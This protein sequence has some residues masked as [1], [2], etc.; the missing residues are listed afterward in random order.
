MVID[1]IPFHL[2]ADELLEQLHLDPADDY[3]D[4]IA[5]LVQK[6]V[7]IARPKVLLKEAYIE[8]RDVDSVTISGAVFVSRV[9]HANTAGIDRVIAF[10]ATCGHELD[11]LQSEYDDPLLLYCLDC[12]KAQ[13]LKTARKRL[14]DV[15]AHQFGM[16]K[17][18]SMSPGSGDASVWPIE[19][20]KQ[21]F[22]LMGDVG[23]LIGVQLTASCLMQ[24][25]KTVSGIIFPTEK[26]FATCQLC[27]REHCPGRQ[28][29]FNEQLWQERQMPGLSM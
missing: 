19:Q 27:H 17:T 23:S 9:L 26:D 5:L 15:V 4:D 12:I 28:A 16:Q 29:P 2:S 18:A 6:A 10:V 13:A 25:N 22:T 3:A 24:P 7:Q 1:T 8:A 20:Q 14:R 21:L 11:A